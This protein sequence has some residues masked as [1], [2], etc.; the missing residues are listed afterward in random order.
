M[1]YTIQIVQTRQREY[2]DGSIENCYVRV[3]KSDNTLVYKGP[4]FFG[5][6]D[7]RIFADG[8]LAGMYN[9]HPKATVGIE[10]VWEHD[11]R[12][13]A[14]RNAVMVGGKD[15]GDRLVVS[16]ARVRMSDADW[17][18]G[19]VVW[20]GIRGAGDQTRIAEVVWN[21]GTRTTERCDV[22][23]VLS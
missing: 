12:A 2:A 16:G 13:K 14:E 11:V 5:L 6:R 1:M 7:A 9:M 21:N 15:A 18:A 23:Q 20:V 4:G 19:E 8:V 3:V 17:R 22:L 10:T